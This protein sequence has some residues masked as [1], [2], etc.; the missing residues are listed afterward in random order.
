MATQLFSILLVLV[1]TLIGAFGALFFKRGS[2]KV[3]L[4]FRA[5]LFNRSLILGF[6]FYVMSAVVFI[7]SLKGGEVS[8]L[9]PFVSLNY[10]WI[11][12]LSIKFL[13]EKMNKWK[14]LG[15]FLIIMG[16][17]LIGLGS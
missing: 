12:L 14:W 7:I 3:S 11:S 16:V 2:D 5:I 15:I 17:S 6:I 13:G 8:V 9:Y 4:N 10:V 1:A